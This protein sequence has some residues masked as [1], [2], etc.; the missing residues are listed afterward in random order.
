MCSIAG[1]LNLTQ[2]NHTTTECEL[3][4]IVEKLVQNSRNISLGQQIKVYT[5]HKNLAYKIFNTERVMRWKLILEEYNPEL[6][7]IQGSKKYCS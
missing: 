3:L 1:K 2:V 7:Y 5:G 4:S 6:I